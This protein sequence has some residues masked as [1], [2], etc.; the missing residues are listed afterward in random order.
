M[1]KQE[2]YQDRLK[3]QLAEA[4][5]LYW[6]ETS[7]FVDKIEVTYEGISPH[8]TDDNIMR[9]TF[10]LRIHPDE[11]IEARKAQSK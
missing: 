2:K 10:N 11:V 4:I 1:E 6:L 5:L 7:V 3:R 8:V 9:G